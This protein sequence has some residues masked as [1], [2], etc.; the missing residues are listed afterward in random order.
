MITFHLRLN[1]LENAFSETRSMKT[2]KL[3]Y[4]PLSVAYMTISPLAKE[5]KT[6]CSKCLQCK[7][8]PL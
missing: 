3:K 5:T 2:T 8:Q 6:L 7:S 1:T 4:S